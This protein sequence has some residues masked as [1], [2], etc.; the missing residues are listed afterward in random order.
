MYQTAELS[1]ASRV[2]Y[3][4]YTGENMLAEIADR[5]T[6][7]FGE[8]RLAIVIDQNVYLH[9]GDRIKVE[10]VDAFDKV[11]WYVVPEGEQ[12]KSVTQWRQICDQLLEQKVRR[13]TPLLAVGGG[14]TGD[15]AGFAAATLLRGIPL[16]HM[17][18]SLLAMVDSSIGGKTGI[19]HPTGKNLIGSFYQPEAVFGD[20]SFL[21]TLEEKEW[22]NGISEIL[23]YAAIADSEIFEECEQLTGPRSFNEPPEW[24]D[25]IS[26][27]MA[28]KANIVEK[29]E[30]EA[31]IRA[32]LNFGHTFGHALEALTD[33]GRF[34]HGEAV[35]LG[36]HAALFVSYEAGAELDYERLQR[37]NTL[38]E[39]DTSGF[40]PRIDELIERMY[41]DKKVRRNTMRLVLLQDWERPY[42]TEW[43]DHEKLREA[44]QYAL[45]QF[46]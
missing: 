9:H 36:M 45:K 22:V 31:G 27:S 35:F 34:S 40:E 11:S 18:T 21:T 19:N 38:Y 44:W 24:R 6:E 39:L 15:L 43:E 10:L 1:L 3:S 23:K 30:R 42:V 46:A 7:R 13:G 33:Y 12:S 28:I 41:F 20:L 16:V 5:L 32:F 4:I 37:F 17:P 2:D 26:K 8:D 29:D 25:I 14:V